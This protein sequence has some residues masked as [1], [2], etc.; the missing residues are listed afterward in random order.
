MNDLIRVEPI[1]STGFK[2]RLAYLIFEKFTSSKEVWVND[3]NS[4]IGIAND[5]YEFKSIVNNYA[6]ERYQ[7][8][9]KNCQKFFW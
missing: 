1:C 4:P 8:L 6:K 9:S 5:E 3:R 7:R 2:V